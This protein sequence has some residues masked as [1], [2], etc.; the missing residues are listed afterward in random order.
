MPSWLSTPEQRYRAIL[1]TALVTFCVSML[2]AAWTALVPFFLGLLFA[3][4]LLPVVSF[5]DQ[6]APRFLRRKGWSRPLAVV[7]VYVIV[8]GAIVGIF[9]SIIPL[10]VKQ[11]R[12]LAEVG[13]DY[14]LAHIEGL[15]SFDIDSLLDKIP[16]SI[17]D[18]VDANLKTAGQTLAGA[19]QKGIEV[20]FRTLSQTVS[21]ILGIIVIPFWLFYILNDQAKAVRGF[22]SLVPEN[23]R[24]DVHCIVKIVN[25]LLSAYIRGQLL[26]GLIV[27]VTATISLLLLQVDLAVLLGTFA[28][29][30]EFIPFLGP[31]IGAFPAILVALVDQPVKALW[32]ALAFLIIQQV[33]NVILVPRISGNAVRFHPAWVIVLVIVGSEVAGIWGLLL[34]VPVA[35]IIRD[36]FQYLY[37]RTTERG[38]T[39][40]MAMGWLRAR[41]G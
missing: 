36:V 17:R 10:V 19:L 29:M 33:E 9:F 20:T 41:R 24:E 18:A 23:A 16:E 5:F 37:L 31:Y 2:F 28:G 26:L 12:D 32:V 11:F 27:G 39:P 13:T 7:I 1:I 3:Y 34:A 38:A 6:H 25:V 4:L 14:Y 40:E 21:F 15:F 8:I 22:Y 30:F 35:A